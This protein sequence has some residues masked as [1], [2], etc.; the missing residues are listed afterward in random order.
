MD[1]ELKHES[2]MMADNMYHQV[3]KEEQSELGIVIKQ[4]DLCA[5]FPNEEAHTE[6]RRHKCDI[7]DKS[8]NIV[9]ILGNT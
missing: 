6:E 3:V 7:C 4:E 8:L 5:L 2:E 9:K 1:P